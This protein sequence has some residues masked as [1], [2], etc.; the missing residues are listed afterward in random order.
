MGPIN[1]MKLVLGCVE[2]KKPT[3]LK[4]FLFMPSKDYSKAHKLFKRNPVQLNKD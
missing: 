2:R 1:I 3:Y 4:E